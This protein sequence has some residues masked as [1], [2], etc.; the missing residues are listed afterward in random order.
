MLVNFVYF[1]LLFL[2]FVI[3]DILINAYYFILVGSSNSS[4]SN[5]RGKEDRLE[6]HIESEIPGE[7]EDNSQSNPIS[8]PAKTTSTK[9][10]VSNERNQIS[11]SSNSKQNQNKTSSPLVSTSKTSS[12]ALSPTK[13]IRGMLFKKIKQ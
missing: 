3:I 1:V 9:I 6:T 7:E 2:T 4:H 10:V 8:D 12:K 11:K 5:S 13:K